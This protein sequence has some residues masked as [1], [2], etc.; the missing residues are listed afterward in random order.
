MAITKAKFT[1]KQT[2]KIQKPA[3]KKS[4]TKLKAVIIRSYEAGVHFGYLKSK[5]PTEVV[6]IKSR[7]IWYWK[8]AN[9]CSDLALTGLD[10]D[11]SKVAP[12]LAEITISR[13]VEIIPCTQKS[14]ESIEGAKWK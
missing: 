5:T 8:G 6:L 2:K 10:A 9:T 4:N 14:I 11:S 1:I 3:A 7:R 13:W 12:Q